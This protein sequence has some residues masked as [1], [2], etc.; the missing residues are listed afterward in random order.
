[1]INRN[2]IIWTD[3]NSEQVPKLQ[4]K[5][6]KNL[7]CNLFYTITSVCWIIGGDDKEDI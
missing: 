5:I 6:K 1:M 4:I 3:L 2:D 7:K